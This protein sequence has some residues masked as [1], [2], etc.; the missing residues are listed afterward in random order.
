MGQENSTSSRSNTNKAN[1]R[2]RE[3]AA[4]KKITQLEAKIQKKNEVVAELL[5][6]HV[7]LKKALG[8]P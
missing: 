5:E 2:R 4:A 1:E 8:E 6:D 7:Q 3:D